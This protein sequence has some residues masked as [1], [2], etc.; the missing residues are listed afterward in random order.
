[1]T[2]TGKWNVV[3]ESPLGEQRRTMTVAATAV[4][5]TGD[6]SGPDGSHP[7]EG[8]IDGDKL[9]WSDKVTSPMP[10]TLQ[11]ETTVAG[12]RMAGTVKLGLFGKAKVTATRI[13]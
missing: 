5:F 1:M 12:D 4:A 11:F 10:L 7:I 13:V 8:K 9:T 6:V 2:A 3:I